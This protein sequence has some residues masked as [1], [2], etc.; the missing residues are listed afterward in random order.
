MRV[1]ETS[2]KVI[3]PKIWSEI[4]PEIK[5]L[6]FRKTFSKNMKE[7]FLSRLPTEKRI[8]KLDL[9]KKSESYKYLEELFNE[10]G[11]DDTFDGFDL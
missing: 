8:K 11:I 5:S 10:T 6:P 3:G 7:L 4:P 1:S 2:I 9:K